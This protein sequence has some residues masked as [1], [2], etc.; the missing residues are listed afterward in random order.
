VKKTKDPIRE[1][2]FAMARSLSTV[3]RGELAIELIRSLMPPPQTQQKAARKPKT[4]ESAA[5]GTATPP[6]S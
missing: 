6:Q 4:Q 2:A 5:T 3:N 1:G